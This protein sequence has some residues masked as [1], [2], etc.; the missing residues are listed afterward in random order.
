MMSLPPTKKTAPKT[1]SPCTDK[2][3]IHL[4]LKTL[5]GCR[6]VV[7]DD[8]VILSRRGNVSGS[9]PA[10]WSQA[11]EL[12][13]HLFDATAALKDSEEKSE[14]QSDGKRD[15][16]RRV[17]VEQAADYAEVSRA[18]MYELIDL[19]VV[20]SG[21]RPGTNRRYVDLDSI[22][23]LYRSPE[24]LRIAAELVRNR[25]KAKDRGK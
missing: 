3:D 7:Y 8:D 24:R 9:N 14:M 16:G 10:V 2:P 23:E 6:V 15:N 5:N 20:V 22:D 13:H 12:F 4:G 21:H 1:G 17:N 18:K 19:K 11:H 25:R